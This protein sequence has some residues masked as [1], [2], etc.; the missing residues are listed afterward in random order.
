MPRAGPAG[1]EV[2]E[3]GVAGR[4]ALQRGAMHGAGGGLRAEQVGGADLHA[5]GAE[6][7][8]RRDALRVGDAAGGDHRDASPPA[9]SAAPARRCR[10]A[11]VRS[12]ERNMPRWPPASRPCAMIGVDA[13]RLEPARLVDRR[14]RGEDLRA[15]G[16]HARQQLGGR[17]AEMEAHDGRPE[18]LEHVGGLGAEGRAPGP[19]GDRAR[20]DA[21]APR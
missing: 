4:V 17:Q 7:Q 13:A 10:P 11:C 5:G 6:R 3:R 8:R 15:P 2:G 21:R 14:R 19:G 16:S 9:R 20:V 18:L 1:E 12:S